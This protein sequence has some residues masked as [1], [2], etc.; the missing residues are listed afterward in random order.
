MPRERAR[1][2]AKWPA[3]SWDTDAMLAGL[4]GSV[5]ADRFE[6]VQAV[7]KGGM[8]QVFRALDRTTN[9]IVA[10]KVLGEAWQHEAERFLREALALERLRHPGI[11]KYVAHGAVAGGGHYLAMEWL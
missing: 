11:V 6:I 9:R 2:C 8:S 3:L 10:L 5:I 7:R 4:P 1:G